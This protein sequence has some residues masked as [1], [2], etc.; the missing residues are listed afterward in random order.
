MPFRDIVGHRRLVDLLARSVKSG[1]LPPS[2]IFAGPSGVGKRLAAL[3]VAQALNCTNPQ[4]TAD[5]SDACGVCAACARIARGVHPDVLIVEPGDSGSIKIDQ[6]RE[7][8]DR[9]GYRPFEG[10]RRA[11]IIDEADALVAG[12]QNALLKTLEEP[13]PSSVF[14]LVTARADTLLATVRSR[15]PRLQFRPLS[16]VDIATV[17]MKLNLSET[18]ARAVAATADGSVGRAL[19]ASA[20]DLVE[21]R[22]IAQRVLAQAADATDPGRRIDGAKDL[23][24]QN[25]DQLALQ[26]RAMA[27]LLRDVEVLATRAD[28]RAL[29]NADVRSAIERL[30]PAYRGERGVRAF[31][32]IDRALVALERNAGVKVVADWLVLQL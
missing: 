6:V 3:S 23:D 29:A 10:K 24:T 4:T 7:I 30:T 14:M 9:A 8:V 25:R 16:P 11:V 28:D 19:E 21:V 31:T 22:E 12:A 26:L 15:C 13:P 27:S 5:T 20:G 17:L 1:A 2:L 18:E 32:A